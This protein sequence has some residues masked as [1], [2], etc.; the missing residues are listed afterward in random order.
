MCQKACDRVVGEGALDVRVM[1][2]RSNL[3]CEGQKSLPA[4]KD[5]AAL[6][7]MV[8]AEN[9]LAFSAV[10]NHEDE[11]TEQSVRAVLAPLLVGVQ[12]DRAVGSAGGPRL[13]EPEARGKFI[14]VVEPGV[15]HQREVSFLVEERLAF[16][17]VFL[18]APQEAMAQG[19]APAA[20]H[21][22]AIGAAMGQG[23]GQA[24][25]VERGIILPIRAQDA[26]N[27]THTGAN[28]RG[29]SLA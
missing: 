8:S 1:P 2:K 29:S 26:K 10:P 17:L 20:P 13:A 23:F 24:L 4:V 21:L 18:R 22:D 15:R 16:E 19:H 6:S 28:D 3:R 14:A 27:R 12:Q 11:V 7:H 5:E 25:K 9:N